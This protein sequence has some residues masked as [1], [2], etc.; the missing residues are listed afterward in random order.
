M[1]DMAILLSDFSFVDAVSAEALDTG[2]AGTSASY[3]QQ[4]MGFQ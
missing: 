3:L 4:I 2:L 1:F